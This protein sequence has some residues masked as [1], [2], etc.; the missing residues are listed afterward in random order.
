MRGEVRLNVRTGPSNEHRIVGGV[1]TGDALRVLERRERWTRVRTPDGKQ[2]WIPGGYLDSEPPPA[3]R[4]ARLEAEAVALR[5]ELET[6]RAQSGKLEAERTAA[7]EAEASQRAEMERLAQENVELRAGAR[8]PELI[9][10]AGILSLGMVL[11]WAWKSS[12]AARRSG[13]RLKL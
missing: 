6:L 2:G 5:E 3:I 11:G 8:W 9:T 13:R 1:K 7:A 4:A 10:G 12:A